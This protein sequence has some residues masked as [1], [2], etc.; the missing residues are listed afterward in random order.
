M[1]VQ[2]KKIKEVMRHKFLMASC[3]TFHSN[4]QTPKRTSTNAFQFD[5]STINSQD[6]GATLMSTDRW[7][8][9][10]DVVHIYSG[11]LLSH[12]ENEIMPFAVTYGPRDNHSKE[13]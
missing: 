1:Y 3:S 5:T 12:K 10:E 7:M 11:I 4:L 13:K 6:K 2:A 8:D 9:K